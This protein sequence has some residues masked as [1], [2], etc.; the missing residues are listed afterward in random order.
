MGMDVYGK[1]PKLKSPKPIRPEN[2]DDKAEMET[3][4]EQ[5]EKFEA[6]NVGFYFRNNVWWWRPLA[7]Y[8]IRFTKV[9]DGKGWGEN[10]GFGADEQEATQI[11]K[12]LFHLIESGHTKEYADRYEKER[13][14]ME[15][16]NKKVG[17]EVQEWQKKNKL[18][19]IAP[20]DYP[21]HHYK[22][23]NKMTKQEKFASHYPFSVKNV[24][25]FAKFSEAS[26]GF[27]I[28]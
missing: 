23:W 14:E 10:S 13:K 26:G 12:Q 7:D 22:T 19:D 8:V 4:F 21:P 9:T 18:T 2:F 27:E 16:H 5:M 25:E 15:L 6:E 3:Y 17:K 24:K 28:C 1:N 20:R 11:A